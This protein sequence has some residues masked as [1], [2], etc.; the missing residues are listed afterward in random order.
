ME[1]EFILVAIDR[2]DNYIPILIRIKTN[3]TL[4][5]MI[6]KYENPDTLQTLVT[7][8]YPDCEDGYFKLELIKHLGDIETVAE[9]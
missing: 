1:N 9:L 8:L 2:N 4:Q 6:E 3:K 7:S 5:S